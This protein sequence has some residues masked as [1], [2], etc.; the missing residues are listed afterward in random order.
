M[1]VIL[2]FNVPQEREEYECAFNG[3]IYKDQLEE[4]WQ[5]CF[6]PSMKHGYPD[7]HIQD[8]IDG[9]H[10]EAILDVIEML[11]NIYGNIIRP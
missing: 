8:L 2:E 4:V 1:K 7:R 9:E 6:R 10:G 11:G 3:S 5:Q